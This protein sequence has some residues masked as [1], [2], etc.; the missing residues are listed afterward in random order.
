M[1]RPLAAPLCAAALLAGCGAADLH[2]PPNAPLPAGSRPIGT[3]TA[4]HPPAPAR[5]VRSCPRRL[6]ARYGAHLELFAEDRVVL[7]PAGIGVGRPM[8]LEQARVTSA[9]CYGPF[10]TLDPTGTVAIRPGPPP[11]LG[12]VF[13]QWG[14]TLTRTRVLGFRAPAGGR[15]R[16]YVGGRE[17]AG[18]PRRVRLF[19]H[20]EVVLEVG[21]YVRPHR[22]YAFQP[23]L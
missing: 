22:S 14:A 13:D 10:V 16:A 4:F 18:D 3:A 9:R 1:R 7:L 21:P 23:P 8:R 5:A 12:D 11:T 19:R 15:V 17:V 6:G 2:R 20:S